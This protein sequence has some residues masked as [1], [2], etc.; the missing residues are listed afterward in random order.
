MATAPM[1]VGGATAD[2]RDATSPE[3]EDALRALNAYLMAVIPPMLD[4]PPTSLETASKENLPLL[5]RFVA[6]PQLIS[7]FLRQTT[8]DSD[9]SNLVTFKWHTVDDLNV[10]LESGQKCCWL[11][12]I[13]RT[14]VLESARPI[15]HQLQLILLPTAAIPDST[16]AAADAVQDHAGTDAAEN[17]IYHVLHAYIHHAVSPFFN[18]YLTGLQSQHQQQQQQPHQATGSMSDLSQGKKLLADTTDNSGVLQDKHAFVMTRIPRSWLKRKWLNWN[19]PCCTYSRMWKFLKLFWLL[20]PLFNRLWTRFV[21][22][23]ETHT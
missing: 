3:S 15:A 22:H 20:I 18:A 11:A 23:G 21:F 17:S 7:L 1:S 4:S 19:C 10:R 13:K 9:A 6:D 16:F 5:Q 12:L 2:S 14:A 8:A